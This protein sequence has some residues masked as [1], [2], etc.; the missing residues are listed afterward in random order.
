MRRVLVTGGTGFV[1][2]NLTRRLLQDG[3]DVHLIVRPGFA[4]WRIDEILSDLT[5]HEVSLTDRDG[6]ERVVSANR[7]EWIFHLAAHGAYSWQRDVD[8][9]IATNLMGTVN[10]LQACLRTGFEAFVNTGSSSE[11]GFKDHAPAENEWLDPN[12]YYAVAKASAS[13]FCRYTAVAENVH[14]PTLR[15]YS[16]YGPYEEPNRLIPSLVVHGLDNRLPPLVSPDTARDFIYVDDVVAAYLKAATVTDQEL[17]AIY[18]IGS[19]CQ[20]TLGELVDIARSVLDIGERPDW[21]SM[22][23]R[24][25]DTDVW[26]ADNRKSLAALNWTVRHSVS[27]GLEK[28]A[29]WFRNTPLIERYR[30]QLYLAAS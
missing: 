28:T 26:V 20:T 30:S 18:N 22:K 27:D 16:V 12:S 11:Y 4:S 6:L 13:M 14:V 7:F 17:G 9:I 21:G 23:N 10:L 29:D 3:H 15:L 19:G 24:N 5:L 1:G 8:Q 25:W 2:A